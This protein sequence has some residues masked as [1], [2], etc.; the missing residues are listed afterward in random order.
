MKTIFKTLTLISLFFSSIAF[1]HIS[2]KKSTPADNAM[3]MTS[4]TGLVL[5]FSSDVRVVRVVLKP[6]F[7]TKSRYFKFRVIF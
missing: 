4:P 1:G 7:R 3:L 5:A 6:T 2:L